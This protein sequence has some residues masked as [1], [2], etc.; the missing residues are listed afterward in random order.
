MLLNFN[1][2]LETWMKSDDYKGHLEN[3]EK[4]IKELNKF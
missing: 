1:D 3:E 4:M 2:K